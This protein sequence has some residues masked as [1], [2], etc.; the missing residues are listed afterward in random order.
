[1]TIKEMI[2]R[3]RELGYSNQQISELSGVPLSTVQKIF[4]GSTGSPRYSTIQAL[5]KVLDYGPNYMVREDRHYRSKKKGDIPVAVC[6]T[7]AEDRAGKTIDDYLSLP[8]GVSVELIDGEFYDMAAPSTIHQRIS[9]MIAS[10][11]ENYISDNNGLCVPFAAPT[12]VQ[13]DCDDKTMVMPDVFVVCDRDKITEQ[14]I[15]GAPDLIIEI[16]SQS[17][18]YTDMEIKRRKYK[19]AGVREYWIVIPKQ[20]KILVY[21][22]EKNDDSIEYTFDDSIPVGIWDGKCTVDF[23][24]IKSK[25]SFLI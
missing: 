21:D 5:S 3:K 11:F 1:M 14:R 16:L 7:E 13:L 25:I 8:E 2:E 12:D 24:N 9:M 10:T 19:A 22:F 4:G 23:E 18:W 20:Q 6:G 17:N 15:Y